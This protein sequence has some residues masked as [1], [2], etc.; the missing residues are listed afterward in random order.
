MRSQALSQGTLGDS[1]WSG[2]SGWVRTRDQEHP[3]L[4][5]GTGVAVLGRVIQAWVGVG[6][7]L[8]AGHPSDG[9]CIPSA[10][11]RA[12]LG[13]SP[14]LEGGRAVNVGGINQASVF[15][16]LFVASFSLVS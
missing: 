9:A 7:C 5:S 10:Q 2:A 13:T 4:T 11:L 8:L 16:I 14:K 6:R 3:G 15:T 1:P 12:G